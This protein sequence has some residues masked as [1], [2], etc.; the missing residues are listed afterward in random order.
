MKA[1]SFVPFSGDLKEIRPQTTL[2]HFRRGKEKPNEIMA[3]FRC[4][5]RRF[6][7]QGRSSIPFLHRRFF[8]F[9]K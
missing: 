5:I 4:S 6:A 7:S 2:I 1:Q 8:S 3:Q 9:N